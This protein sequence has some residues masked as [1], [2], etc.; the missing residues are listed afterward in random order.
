[1]D[2]MERLQSRLL[3]VP[4]AVRYLPGALR[5]LPGVSRATSAAGPRGQA[6][7]AVLDR[8]I[9]E[10]EELN[11]STERD[12]LLVGERLMQFRSTTRSMKTEMSGLIDLISGEESRTVSASLS[13]M[14][15]YSKRIEGEIER[16][17]R[18]FEQV[19][20][21]AA[22][23]P[24]AFTG[25]RNMVQVFRT[26]CTLTRIETSRL[27][28]SE[29]DF[30]DLAAEV[31]PLSELLQSG[32]EAVLG[33]SARLDV[34][35]QTALS[36]GAELRTRQLRELPELIGAVAGGSAAFEQRQ[37]RA[38]ELS[39]AQLTKYQLLSAATDDLVKAIQFHD[40]TRQ[41][42]EHVIQALR[43]LRTRAPQGNSVS[44]LPPDAGTVIALQCSQLSG[45]A[46]TF[47]ES[48]GHM[49][50]S[51]GSISRRAQDMAEA[52][53]SLMGISDGERE[54]FFLEMERQCT[55]ILKMLGSC[56]EEQAQMETTAGVLCE[57]IGAMRGSVA[58]IRGIELSIQRI[59]LNAT[60][61]AAHI[62]AAGNT[63]D[64]IAA[65]MQGLARDSNAN[66][67]T[68]G[69]SLEQMSAAL[70]RDSGAS[71][72]WATAQSG[73]LVSELRRTILD[74]HSASESSF[75]RVNQITEMGAGMAGEIG[76]IAGSM[77]AGSIFATTTA[78]VLASLECFAAPGEYGGATPAEHLQALSDRYTMQAERDV[79]Q[80]VLGGVAQTSHSEPA[81]AVEDDLGDNIE[82]F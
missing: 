60:I 13:G 82:L 62:G 1:M 45:A 41:Q 54:S 31:M 63:L 57:D 59:A 47:A 40:I 36:K 69:R 58:Q 79:H 77:S 50:T 28:N 56:Q 48:V 2:G 38:A 68:V 7:T 34:G 64:V 78:R 29:E 32:G 21:S 67:E 80:A 4:R 23:I 5:R 70:D 66:T 74:L 6:G 76:A 55:D 19:H 49:E 11:R 30:G 26:L 3:A 14:L 33:A 12:F 53:R 18:A 20:E 8:A 52:S 17:G 24:Q 75:S 51:L 44:G 15:T 9:A 37:V 61:R 22:A 42:V 27:G 72:A 71:A 65:V 39:A 81:V 73:N 43:E 16:N 25:L 10:L 35:V 46:R